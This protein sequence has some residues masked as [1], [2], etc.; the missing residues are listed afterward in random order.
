MPIAF[1]LA[2]MLCSEIMKRQVRTA[3]IDMTAQEA[4]RLMGDNQIGFLPVCDVD[5]RPLGVITDRDLALRV[6]AENLRPE[7]TF[8]SSVMTH[9]PLSCR[10]DGSV[11]R[12]QE[13]M[14]RHKHRRILLLDEHGRLVG[15]I[16]FADL[17]HYQDPFQIAH[18]VRTLSENRLRVEK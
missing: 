13:L 6:C 8:L 15:L 10:D 14:L 16:T 9:H 18:F 1:C 4:A 5:R 2:I 7:S 12:A 17:V 11:E 3:T